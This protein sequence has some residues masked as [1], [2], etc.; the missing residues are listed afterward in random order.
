MKLKYCAV[1]FMT[2]FLTVA[3]GGAERKANKSMAK[4]NE[5][6]LALVEK[7]QKCVKKAGDNEAEAAACETYRKSAE[8]LQ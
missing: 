6:R 5:E 3:C 4:V 1:I 2:A 7:Y 8:A